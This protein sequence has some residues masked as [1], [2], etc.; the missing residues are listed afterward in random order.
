MEDFTETLKHCMLF[1]ELPEEVIRTQVLPGGRL[2]ECGKNATLISPQEEVE[3]FGVLLEGRVQM[4]QIFPD[5]ERSLMATLRP[6]SVLGM[7]FICA[8]NRQSPYFAV[9]AE[10]ARLLV[11]RKEWLG[12]AEDLTQETR[13]SI[14]SQL[15]T[16]ISHDNIRQSSRIFIL[17]KRGLRDRILTYLTTQAAWRRSSTFSI[18]YSREE[19]AEF[20]CVNRSALSHQLSLMARE[21]L[22]SVW[23][24]R[25][26][27]YPPAGGEKPDSR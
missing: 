4:V 12:G 20:L 14:L 13:L 8:R 7:E 21:G 9:A 6:P 11:F 22:I 27:I 23:K 10:E 1:R 26:T 15:A 16:L 3:W 24:N 2:L 18:P 17:S 25:F 19:L 5:G